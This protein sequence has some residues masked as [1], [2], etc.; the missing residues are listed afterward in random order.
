MFLERAFHSVNRIFSFA[1][2]FISYFGFEGRG[3]ALNVPVPRH[4]SQ[5]QL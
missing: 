2:L 3:C 1:I 5:L 4:F